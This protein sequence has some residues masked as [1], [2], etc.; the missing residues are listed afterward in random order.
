M[1]SS[2][3]HVFSGEALGRRNAGTGRVQGKLADRDA[4]AIGAE[5]AK[6]EN[7]LAVGHDDDAHVLVWPVLKNVADPALVVQGD[8]KPPRFP[9]KVLELLAGL[10]H[11]RRV[12]DGH[13]LLDVVHHDA[14]EQVLVAV[15]Q[16]DQVKV[17]FE[18]R[19]FFPKVAENA[20][21]LL[22]HRMHAGR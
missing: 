15:L 21:F 16:C 7:S 11:G 8:I 19:R 1:S 22:R 9:V 18:V 12:D 6:A 4:H 10:A 14:V 13:H 17:L 2:K 20:Q 3:R 5:I